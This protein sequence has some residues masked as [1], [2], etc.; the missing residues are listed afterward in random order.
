MVHSICIHWG[1]LSV[2]SVLWLQLGKLNTQIGSFVLRYF[3]HQISPHQRRA[4]SWWGCRELYRTPASVCTPRFVLFSPLRNSW[5][6]DTLG[7]L[8]V[9]GLLDRD[10]STHPDVWSVLQRAV[11]P[12]WMSVKPAP[13]CSPM[14]VVVTIIVIITHRTIVK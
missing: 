9:C 5:R 8:A 14:S 7:M 13:G 10:T 4:S 3:Y 11:S 6:T 1:H 12:Q 2:R